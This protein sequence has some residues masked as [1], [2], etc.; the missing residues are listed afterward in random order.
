M[1]NHHR[2]VLG[3]LYGL[4][5]VSFVG[6]SLGQPVGSWISTNYGGWVTLE[7]V[8]AYGA[9]LVGLIWLINRINKA[10][11]FVPPANPAPLLGPMVTEMQFIR[12]L[13]ASEYSDDRPADVA[14]DSENGPKA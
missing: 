7:A 8:V 14:S 2:P 9:Y 6:M 4:L 3:F 13:K 11:G 12:N 1:L 10:M 5:F